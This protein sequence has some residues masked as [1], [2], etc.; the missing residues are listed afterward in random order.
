[1]NT[2][3]VDIQVGWHQRTEGRLALRHAIKEGRGIFLFELE[4][5]NAS[6]LLMVILC[7]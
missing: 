2:G 5:G 6:Q 3:K 7:V 1:M 4:G